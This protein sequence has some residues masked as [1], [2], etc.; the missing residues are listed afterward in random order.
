MF[1]SFLRIERTPDTMVRGFITFP[2]EA[3]YGICVFR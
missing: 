2:C 3:A 1:R